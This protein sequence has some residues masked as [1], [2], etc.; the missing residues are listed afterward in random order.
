MSSLDTAHTSAMPSSK[1]RAMLR[2]MLV[3]LDKQD[4]LRTA[5]SS[6]SNHWG[7]RWTDW[8]LNP[9]PS[10]T[11]PGALTTELPG[12]GDTGS[13]KHLDYKWGPLGCLTTALSMNA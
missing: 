3:A 6:C 8:G 2:L 4:V 13:A 7:K 12:L 10:G 1:P 11:A 9:G 5:A